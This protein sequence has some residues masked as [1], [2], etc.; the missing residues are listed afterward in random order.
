M[1]TSIL[2][3]ETTKR[4]VGANPDWLVDM[5]PRVV[6][7]DEIYDFAMRFSPE[8]MNAISAIRSSDA[9][10]VD[11]HRADIVG[12]LL[13]T[14]LFTE[15]NARAF[16][17]LK[18]VSRVGTG[19]DN[20]RVPKDSGIRVEVAR[21]S[22]AQAVVSYDIQV[23]M[24]HL[25]HERLS[26]TNVFPRMFSDC[27]FGIIGLGNI[28][29]HLWYTLE[30]MAGPQVPIAA[31]DVSNNVCGHSP[32]RLSADDVVGE[33][34][35]LFVHIPLTVQNEGFINEKLLS[36]LPSGAL[37]VAPVRRG[38][39]DFSLSGNPNGFA[40]GRGDIHVVTD[41]NCERCFPNLYDTRHTA[42]RSKWWFLSMIREA[43][44][45]LL[46]GIIRIDEEAKVKAHEFV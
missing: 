15:E 31:F 1:E 16:P 5:R 21:N 38:V 14:E 40:F 46:C 42:T 33:S 20:V 13:G 27:R 41:C 4:V 17:N 34:D 26:E 43:I 10:S 7:S 6:V 19:V 8:L 24:H 36:N 32:N 18:V 29:S 23:A 45:N 39:F 11:L 25:E 9:E 44:D 3:W 28:G 22:T 30:C 37:V 35:I 12:V 2:G